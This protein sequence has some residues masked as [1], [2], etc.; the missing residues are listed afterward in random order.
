MKWRAA[1]ESP[2]VR[3]RTTIAGSGVAARPGL[4]Y[5]M[6]S[7]AV[8]PVMLETTPHACPGVRIARLTC[9][10]STGT[11]LVSGLRLAG[12]VLPG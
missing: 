7:F 5:D 10:K 8:I 2:T 1:E 3:N 11:S 12:G 4:R 9:L 6:K